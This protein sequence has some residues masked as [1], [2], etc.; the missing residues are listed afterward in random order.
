MGRLGTRVV[1][2]QE[3]EYTVLTNW[4]NDDIDL[5]ILL[6]SLWMTTKDLSKISTCEGWRIKKIWYEDCI[7][8]VKT[9]LSIL[10][11][12]TP[13]IINTVYNYIFVEAMK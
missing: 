8:G 6:L 13:K 2:C 3:C 4:R 9:L 12:Y 5:I 7:L 11:G 10:N 1:R